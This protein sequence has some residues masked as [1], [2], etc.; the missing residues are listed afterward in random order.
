[1]IYDKYLGDEVCVTIENDANDPYTKIG[2]KAFLS[3]K[4]ITE[5]RLPNTITEIGS[6]AFSHMKSLTK[7]YI[8]ANDIALGKG[9]FLDCPKLREIVIYTGNI[10]QVNNVCNNSSGGKKDDLDNP[11]NEK[12]SAGRDSSVYKLFAASQVKMN[13]RDLFLPKLAV[14]INDYDK[15]DKILEAESKESET[16]HISKW[17]QLFDEELLKFIRLPDET[18]F[19]GVLIGWFNDEGEEEQLEKYKKERQKLK[20]ELCFLRLIND[21]GLNDVFR[22]AVYAYLK[23]VKDSQSLLEYLTEYVGRN[24]ELAKCVVETG[25]FDS[26]FIGLLIDEIENMNPETEVVTY[27]LSSVSSDK[28]Q[29]AFEMFDI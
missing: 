27:L 3:C 18:G 19:K 22:K 12:T 15:C 21:C 14:Q 5:I 4:N 20:I 26:K 11:F 17:F 8:P 10:N 9:V 23:E 28:K 1:M 2:D 29:D 25:V 7:L 16:K 6:W 24:L 13:C